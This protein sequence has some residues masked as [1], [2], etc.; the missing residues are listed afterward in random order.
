MTLTF[1][2]PKIKTQQ[3]IKKPK[4]PS[5][6]QVML[7]APRFLAFLL[8]SGWPSRRPRSEPKKTFQLMSHGLRKTF[9]KSKCRFR[10]FIATK[11]DKK[12][13]PTGMV[14]IDGFGNLIESRFGVDD[15][16]VDE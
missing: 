1:L 6:K 16:T 11:S 7:L 12:Y 9:T 14:A 13:S 4:S 10:R 8:R 5:E 3:S 2:T 15:E